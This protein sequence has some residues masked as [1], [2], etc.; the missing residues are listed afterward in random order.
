MVSPEIKDLY[1]KLNSQEGV[2]LY[3]DTESDTLSYFRWEFEETWRF[4]VPN[5]SLFL[6]D[7]TQVRE[8]TPEEY[9]PLFCY[10]TEKS[11]EIPLY[12]TEAQEEN[13]ISGFN[14]QFI[15]NFSE[16]LGM[17][18]S[19]LLKQYALT[20]EAFSYWSLV[21]KNSEEIGDIFGTMPTELTGN[22]TC[23]SHPDQKIVG[24]V[25]AGKIA[26]KRIFINY[27]DLPIPWTYKFVYYGRCVI[28]PDQ[29]VL[30][31]E[32]DAFF[33]AHPQFVPVDETAPSNPLAMTHYSYASEACLDC[34]YRG[35][36]EPP[37]FWEN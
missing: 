5:M 7:G 10:N 35:S 6:Y 23:V 4:K 30:K 19:I 15:P 1:W 36:V 8:R 20:K 11:S 2:R 34:S 37:A 21:K 26:Q 32:A 25:E 28:T 24:L 33:A 18:Y 3:L 16:K 13:T 9:Y 12:S 14:F 17:R 22:L 29:M 27:N 31:R